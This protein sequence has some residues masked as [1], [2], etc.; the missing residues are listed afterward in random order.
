MKS[1]LFSFL[2]L[3]PINLFGQYDSLYWDNLNRTYFLHLPEAYTESENFPLVIA[4]HG[5]FGSAFNLQN[6]SMLSDKAD[7]ESFI[8][9]YPEGVLGG[10]NEIRTW[11]AGWCCGHASFNDIDDIGFINTLLDTLIQYYSVDTNRIYATGMSNGGFLSYR[12]ACELSDRIAAIAPVAASMSMTS[13]EPTRPVPVL[14]F[15]SYLD[16]NVPLIGGF[17]TGASSLYS[18]P[19]DSVLNAWSQLNSCEISNDTLVDNDQITQI[20]WSNCECDIL[21]QQV[22][23]KDGGHSWPGGNATPLGDPVSEFVNANDLIWDFFQ[24]YSL[25]CTATSM[26]N[27]DETS[28]VSIYPNP[29]IDKIYLSN[30]GAHEDMEMIIY[31]HLGH[32]IK[33]LAGNWELDL[34]YWPKGN[35][36]LRV[37]LDDRI[38]VRK[39]VKL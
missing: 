29:T 12:L 6:Q 10:V 15:H 39:I 19:L 3:I 14:D 18:A 2:V 23:T 27:L 25:E 5:G 20:Q 24:Q 35:Y 11:N 28:N 1:F 26:D 8:V 7:D 30:I 22:I 17:G 21:V 33:V 32:Q 9:V 13:C 34:S 16:T 4:M 31:N 37:R 36:F 38:F